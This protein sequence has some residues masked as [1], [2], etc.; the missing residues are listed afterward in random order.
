MRAGSS[1]CASMD[2]CLTPKP[3]LDS[4]IRSFYFKF[5]DYLVGNIHAGFH[6]RKERRILDPASICDIPMFI[7][8]IKV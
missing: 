4:S 2:G 7:F 5:A 8:Y 6:G 1:R 3:R